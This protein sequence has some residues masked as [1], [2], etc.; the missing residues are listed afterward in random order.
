[1][2]LSRFAKFRPSPALAVAIAALIVALSGVAYATIP[3]S[4]G[5]IHGC[6][7][8]LTGALRVINA[9]TQACASY[10]VPI[11]WDQ[12][13]QQGPPGSTS[14]DVVTSDES[15]G[16]PGGTSLVLACPT[17]DVALSGGWEFPDFPDLSMLTSMS[18]S[19]YGSSSPASG[20]PSEPNQWDFFVQ[21]N[22]T[23]APPSPVLLSVVCET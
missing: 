9:P 18:D 3:S 4:S 19:A 22:N 17:G 11:S 13:G 16:G 23:T 20:G 2:R 14:T 1:V 12:T 21:N 6:Y 10:Q 5:L 15:I 8:K 7:S